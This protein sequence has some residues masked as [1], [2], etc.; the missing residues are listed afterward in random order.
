MDRLPTRPWF[1]GAVGAAMVV[2]A[3]A[4]ALGRRHGNGRHS[5]RLRPVGAMS[6]FSI[7][8]GRQASTPSGRAAE[9]SVK[10]KTLVK[11]WVF[12][13]PRDRVFAYW[14]AIA[15]FPDFLDSIESVQET[16]P[17]RYRMRIRRP[18]GA[19]ASWDVSVVRLVPGGLI[20]W[21][22]DSASEV[23][24]D[25][26]AEFIPVEGGGTLVEVRMEYGSAASW[27]AEG[28]DRFLQSDLPALISRDVLRMKEL[29]ETGSAGL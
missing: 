10:R 15:E 11:R 9:A 6:R 19:A 21:A 4:Y 13:A 3:V 23:K 17:G 5:L 2:T 27:L 1:W 29:I 22:S 28:M 12:N 7:R 18:A 16:Q 26:I 24:C 8:Q 25:G 20:E 14:T